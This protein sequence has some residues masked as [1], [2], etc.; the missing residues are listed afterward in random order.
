MI[1]AVLISIQIESNRAVLHKATRP[2]IDRPRITKRKKKPVFDVLNK[3]MNSTK[4]R[5]SSVG[6]SSIT[7]DT[8]MTAGTSI[9]TGS[10]AGIV[11]M[12]HRI[13]SPNPLRAPPPTPQESE[14]GTLTRR[15]SSNNEIQVSAATANQTEATRLKFLTLPIIASAHVDS[16][17]FTVYGSNP[18]YQ[19]LSYVIFDVS[20]VGQNAILRTEPPFDTPTNRPDA[21]QLVNNY[22]GY[23]SDLKIEFTVNGQVVELAR[24]GVAECSKLIIGQHWTNIICLGLKELKLTTKISSTFRSKDMGDPT[25]SNT[26]VSALDKFL[27]ALKKEQIQ[28]EAINVVAHLSYQHS[29]L[30][31]GTRL[32]T[33]IDCSINLIGEQTNN[34]F[35][36][37]QVINAFKK[38]KSI[39]PGITRRTHANSVDLMCDMSMAKNIIRVLSRPEIGSKLTMISR[40]D[41]VLMTTADAT[42]ALRLIHDFKIAAGR[43]LTPSVNLDLSRLVNYYEMTRNGQLH[44]HN[45]L[46]QKS[47]TRRAQAAYSKISPQ[48]L[49]KPKSL[50]PLTPPSDGL[51]GISH[52]NENEYLTQSG[53]LHNF[54]AVHIS[55]YSSDY[56]DEM[57]VLTDHTNRFFPLGSKDHARDDE[58]QPRFR[59]DNNLSVAPLSYQKY[60]EANYDG[61]QNIQVDNPPQSPST[62]LYDHLS[63]NTSQFSNVL[64]DMPS[65][66]AI[67]KRKGQVFERN[68]TSDCLKQDQITNNG[69]D[70]VANI[71]KRIKVSSGVNEIS[72]EDEELLREARVYGAPWL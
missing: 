25:D 71:W 17:T 5:F 51:L 12:L 1:Q 16:H 13:D 3:V 7:I 50:L 22:P 35:D 10:Q 54:S 63:Q 56:E 26:T 27:G 48:R 11:D 31:T 62:H 58:T 45:A 23:L 61:F 57:P 30:P 43:F 2:L 49:Y 69:C 42:D 32:S 55:G 60:S 37:E 38:P 19:A 46:K 29:F 64:N 33:D 21:T 67:E 44:L 59:N 68:S 28:S 66:D 6:S 18:K 4:D 70:E 8:S 40:N 34:T 39:C 52:E 9:S 24:Y 72:D 53:P 65:Q 14:I 47:I 36:Q 20:V 41:S 15:N